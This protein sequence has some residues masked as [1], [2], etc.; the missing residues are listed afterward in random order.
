[1]VIGIALRG[2]GKALL[3]KGGKKGS[4]AAKKFVERRKA[5]R[6]KKTDDTGDAAKKF[7]ERRR[8]LGNAAF[9]S[10]IGQTVGKAK[11]LKKAI[12]EAT[13]RTQKQIDMLQGKKKK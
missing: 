6:G 10:D 12:Q 4:D 7:K 8:V 11:K 3:K 1:M 2:I 9:Q 13:A 5:L